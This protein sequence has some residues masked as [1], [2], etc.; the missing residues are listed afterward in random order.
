[1]VLNPS[2]ENQA[3][4]IMNH[5]SCRAAEKARTSATSGLLYYILAALV[6]ALT[7]GACGVP[8]APDAGPPSTR[9]L[10]AIEE[11]NVAPGAAEE[12]ARLLEEARTA[13][14]AGDA[15]TALAGARRVVEEFPEA[16]GSS[17]ALWL[18]AQAAEDLEEHE[19][20]A[21]AAE[22]F[23]SVLPAGHPL[24]VPALMLRGRALMDAGEWEEGNRV[25]FELPATAPEETRRAALDD[26]RSAASEMFFLALE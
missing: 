5:H 11:G 3:S 18:T 17:E 23:R 8:P 16:P 19:S 9:T 26:V 1:M 22:E 20:A 14:E 6:T 4:R 15:E 13:L 7:V 24:A 12:A 10:P 25:L 21:D 2:P